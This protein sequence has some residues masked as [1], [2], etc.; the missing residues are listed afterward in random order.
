MQWERPLNKVLKRGVYLERQ[1]AVPRYERNRN[2][3][4]F[5]ETI[6]ARKSILRYSDRPIPESDVEAILRAGLLAPSARNRQN[7]KF[8]VVRDP[9]LRDELV[10]ACNGQSMVGEAPAFLAVCSTAGSIMP[11]GQPTAPIDAAIA[12][13]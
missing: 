6:T 8:I 12:A 13:P 1:A 5:D 11:N 10:G 7:L 9:M 4:T 2:R 3:M